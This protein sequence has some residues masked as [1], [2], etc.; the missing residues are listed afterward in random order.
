MTHEPSAFGT[1]RTLAAVISVSGVLPEA[2]SPA[3]RTITQELTLTSASAAATSLVKVV[4]PV[5]VT[6]TWPS[7]PWT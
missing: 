3:G 7:A 5:H 1:I 2:G 6:A 4:L